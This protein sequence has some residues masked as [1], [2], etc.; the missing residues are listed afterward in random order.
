MSKLTEKIRHKLVDLNMTQKELAE[1]IG[2]HKQVVANWISGI[3]SPKMENLSK[4]AKIFNVSV[5]ELIDDKYTESDGS[6]YMSEYTA[7][8]ENKIKELEEKLKFKDE[9]IEFLREK[10]KMLEERSF[11]NI[12]CGSSPQ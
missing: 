8:A 1:R 3:R 12:D 10:I 4:I 2:V 9:Q 7:N 6:P 5:H 11:M